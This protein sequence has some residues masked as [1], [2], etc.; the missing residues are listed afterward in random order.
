MFQNNNIFICFFSTTFF[1]YNCAIDWTIP[2]E[3]YFW[4]ILSISSLVFLICK[5]KWFQHFSWHFV[6]FKSCCRYCFVLFFVFLRLFSS[7]LSSHCTF[8]AL[9]FCNLGNALL[10]AW[11]SASVPFKKYIPGWIFYVF[12]N[13]IKISCPGSLKNNKTKSSS[14][15]LKLP[16]R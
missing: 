15:T 11:Y 9:A 1:F 10:S 13:N 4:T 14:F 7:W 5:G 6:W 12:G 16:E 3:T 2:W 8:Q